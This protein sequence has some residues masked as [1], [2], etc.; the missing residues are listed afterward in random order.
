MDPSPAPLRSDPPLARAAATRAGLPLLVLAVGVA[1]FTLTRIGLGLYTGIAEVPARY[2]PGM[3]GKGLGFDLATLAFLLAPVFAYEALLPDRWR[4]SR[5]H[6]ALRFGWLAFSAFALLFGAVAETTFWLEFS[7]RFNF[8][9]VDYLLYTQEVVD[10]IVQS[11]P[12]GWIIAALLAL[13]LGVAAY[14]W[15]WVATG[16]RQPFSRRGRW[17]YAL[18]AA[19]LPLASWAVADSDRMRG[20][21]NEFADELAGNGLFTFAAALRRN[22]LDYDLLYRTIPQ[23]RADRLL[24]GLGVRRAPLA[25]P[26]A[27]AALADAARTDTPI[28]DPAAGAIAQAP[29]LSFKRR[30]RNIVL[31]SIESLSAEFVGAWGATLG[32]T[33]RLDRL[34]TEGVMLARLFATGTRTVRGLEALSL[35]TPPV[36]GQAIVRRPNNDQLSTLG[37]L[38]KRQGWD[39]FYFYG[40][41]G[42]FDNMNAYFA[43]NDYQVV[44]RTDV[45]KEAVVF[46]NAWGVADEVLFGHA[47]GVMDREAAAGRPFFA[48]VMTTSNHRPYTYPDGR[49]DIPSPGGRNGAVKYTDWAI[50]KFIDDARSHPWFA[51]TLFVLVADH[52][53]S[54]AGRSKLPVQNYLIP[55]IL[56]APELLS[57][58]RRDET[59]SQM[60]LVPTMLDALGAQ[61]SEQ[62]FGRSMLA[63]G[64]VPQRAFISNYQE[65]GYLRDGVLT[66]L[67]PKRGIEAYRID[68]ATLAATPTP[69]EHRLQDEAIAYYQS[70]S[71]AFKAGALK[72]PPAHA[73]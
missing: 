34:A 36:P 20:S 37:L 23:E 14:A 39:P 61:G 57:P 49:I 59:L 67:L 69:V 7:T 12:V 60:D 17:G 33:P 55:A 45:P 53:A 21:G 48:H 19:V 2:W 10:N 56:Y 13:A 68:P 5:W 16:D 73:K 3:L 15:R 44:D 47:L 41:Y 66:I 8:I 46:E 25:G 50:G 72:A 58:G 62:F 43:A 29:L 22:E 40:G 71:R 64:P 1:I 31:V 18:L 26:L 27:G 70:A 65:L 63:P 52:C 35:G 32:L 38:L 24:A 4:A 51:D 54:V 30:P 11:Y 42:Y 6:A 28:A 9:A